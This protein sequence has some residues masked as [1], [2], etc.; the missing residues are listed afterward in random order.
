MRLFVSFGVS[1]TAV[2]LLGPVV[3]AAGFSTLLWSMAGIAAVTLCAVALLPKTGA[4]RITE[5]A[6]P[7][8]RS[9][10]AGD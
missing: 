9:R 2:W 5:T 3:K 6:V 8:P 4:P 10:P 7:L 1:S